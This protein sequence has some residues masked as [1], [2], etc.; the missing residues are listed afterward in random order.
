[1]RMPDRPNRV[2]VDVYSADAEKELQQRLSGKVRF[3]LCVMPD[4]GTNE[5]YASIKRWASSLEGIASQCAKVNKVR[6]AKMDY[7]SNLLLKVNLKL[8]GHN[9]FPSKGGLALLDETPTMVL[10]ADVYH[11]PPGS[12]RPSFSALVAAI[13]SQCT[14]WRSE[15]GAQPSRTEPIIHLEEMVFREIV[16][17]QE[18]RGTHPRR[19]IFFRDGVAHSQFCLLYTSPSPRDKRQSRMPSSA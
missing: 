19:L 9:S 17:F 4:K 16:R 7:I 5:L 10:G 3:I 2:D 13:D 11:A 12:S 14:E 15:V 1:M 8:G 18:L 6:E